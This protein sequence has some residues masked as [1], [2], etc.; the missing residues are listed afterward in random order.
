MLDYKTKISEIENK[1]TADHDHDKHVTTQEFDQLTSENFTARLAEAN[2]GSTNDI[3][4]FVKKADL[5][6]N[7]LNEP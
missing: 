5:K 3:A 4:N 2:L 1:V 6:T 7:E